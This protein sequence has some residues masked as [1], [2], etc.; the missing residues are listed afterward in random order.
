MISDYLQLFLE[1]LDEQLQTIEE[2]IL[3][4]E[5]E[6]GS[7][8]AIQSLFRAAHT[9][10]GSSAAM[11]FEDMQQLTHEMEHL[12][13]KVRSKQIKVTDFLIN[14][15]FKSLDLLKQLKEIVVGGT[16][17]E[18]DISHVIAELRSF[19]DAADQNPTLQNSLSVIKQQP[20][21]NTDMKLK[22]EEAQ[23]RGL[24]AFWIR[25]HIA[26]DC[27]LKRARAVVIHNHI[28]EWAQLLFA[29]PDP[30]A[31]GDMEDSLSELLFLLATEK[32]MEEMQSIVSS[33]VEVTGAEI[34]P[35]DYRHWTEVRNINT[36]ALQAHLLQPKSVSRPWPDITM[37]V[38]L[39]LEEAQNNGMQSFWIRLLISEDC[40]LKKARTLVIYNQLREWAD[41]W[42]AEPD[43]DLPGDMDDLVSEAV[44]LLTT[45]KTKEELQRSVSSL[46][47]VTGA[48]IEPV[49]YKNWIVTD[50]GKP[51]LKGGSVKENIANPPELYVSAD[52]SKS[53]TVRVSVERLD[54]L[55]NLVGELVIDR[56]R[57][58]QVEK[59]LSQQFASVDSVED[60]GHISDHLS[61]VISELQESVMKARMLPI[62]QLFSRFPRL[63]RDL[64]QKLNKEVDLIIEGKETELDRTLIEDIADPMIH[65]IRNAIDHGIETPDQREQAGKNPR[66]TLTL[67]AAHEDNSVVIYIKNDGVGIDPRKIKASAVKKGII[68]QEEAD[69]LS[70][71]E[72]IQLIFLSGFSTAQAVSDVS[73][74]GVGMDIVKSNIEKMNGII[75]IETD[76]RAGTEFKIKLPLTLAIITGLLVRLSGRTY[77]IPM[78]NIAEIVRVEKDGIQSVRGESVIVLRNLVI[79]VLRLHEYLNIPAEASN[80]KHLSLVIVGSAE[81]RVAVVVDELLGNQEVVLKSLGGY[82]GK[83]DLISGATILGDGNVALIL[84]ASALVGKR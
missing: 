75:D 55:M 1:E 66:G 64:S 49:D 40:V 5:Q 44:F 65:I 47:E 41:V 70:E 27:I 4:L 61:R 60:L 22:L 10:K 18:V 76:L 74:R 68:S 7:E 37:E 25:L 9:L 50:S 84:E 57:I 29:E 26:E 56:T 2:E 77:V 78:S 72:A 3:N 15:L 58:F 30:E 73:G 19:E 8:K 14:Q 45:E 80:K 28:L 33:L 51:G 59:K 16:G 81:K 6:G 38:R 24:R 32:T 83:V 23:D 17:N 48:E 63:V 82:L 46:V 42:F 39:R 69:A 11:G 52:K 79:P 36:K 54:H 67:R 71:R 53:Q 31:T 13:D 62:E 20:D 43:P 35:F 34:E 21:V 12:L